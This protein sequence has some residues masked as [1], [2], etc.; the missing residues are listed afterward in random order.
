VNCLSLSLCRLILAWLRC[1]GAPAREG[2]ISVVAAR[3]TSWAVR[4]CTNPALCRSVSLVVSPR[5]TKEWP[6][7]LL[8]PWAFREVFYSFSGPGGYLSPTEGEHE[9]DGRGSRL[10]ARRWNG[11]AV[12]TCTMALHPRLAPAREFGVGGEWGGPEG[13][14]ATDAWGSRGGE[15]RGRRIGRG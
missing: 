5:P 9:I 10:S 1:M 14:D 7:D 6:Y 4:V 8:G 11:G 2:R 13:R 3:S 12:S 15:H